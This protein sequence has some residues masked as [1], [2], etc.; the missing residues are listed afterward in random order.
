MD[1][2]SR[3][4]AG[5]VL[6]GEVEYHVKN[7]K[8]SCINIL[9]PI[10]DSGSVLGIVGVNID[11]TEHKEAVESLHKSEAKYRTLFEEL[12]SGFSYHQVICDEFGKPCDYRF[13]EVNPAFERLTGLTKNQVVGKRVLEILPGTEK[14]WIERYGHVALTGETDYSVHM[15]K[16]FGRIYES[17]AFCPEYG[18][19]AVIFNDVTEQYMAEEKIQFQA[20]LL[21]QVRNAVFAS[22]LRGQIT[23][24][25][26]YAETLYKYTVEEAIGRQIRDLIIPDASVATFQHLTDSMSNNEYWEGELEVQSKDGKH[27]PVYMTNALLTDKEGNHSGYVGI[28]ADISERVHLEEQL[29]HAHKMEAVGRLAGGIAH[30][31]NNILTAIIGYGNM[32]NDKLPANSKEREQVTVILYSAEKAAVLTRAL[33]AFS[34]K[35]IIVPQLFDVNNTVKK[36]VLLLSRLIGEDINLQTE[37]ANMPLLVMADAGQIEQVLINLATNARDSMTSGGE[38]LIATDITSLDSEYL[39]PYGHC[40]PGLY[41]HISFAD[42]GSGIPENVR[43]KIFDPFFTT[44]EIGKGTGL[45]LSIAHGVITQHKGFITV[46]SALNEGS[47]F[48]IYLPVHEGEEAEDLKPPELPPVGGGETILLVEDDETVRDLTQL[49]LEMHGYTVIPA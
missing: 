35:E 39:E 11:I 34:R 6:K 41:A 14:Y 27:F 23:Y 20:S 17:R 44:K 46:V 47:T 15:S 21:D 8:R 3:A 38:I 28:T 33:L 24:W 29:Q 2:N 42:S 26:R 19:F 45:G 25:N 30:D 13:I 22:D 7:E 32:L 48:H 40:S 49:V 31:F 1:N 12:M 16:E 4:F 43:A 36:T 10:I 9:A 37:L 18:K 5:E